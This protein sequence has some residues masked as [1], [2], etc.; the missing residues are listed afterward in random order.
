MFNALCDCCSCC[1][2][3]SDREPGDLE[4]DGKEAEMFCSE[5]IVSVYQEA[6]ILEQPPLGPPPSE[7]IPRDFAPTC[8]ANVESSLLDKMLG[9]LKWIERMD[10]RWCYSYDWPECP[11]FLICCC[12][13]TTQ[14]PCFDFRECLCSCCCGGQPDKVAPP[15]FVIDDQIDDHPPGSQAKQLP[16]S[17]SKGHDVG[18]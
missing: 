11:C 16:E 14:W 3:A 9:D 13:C 7:Y 8:N 2:R 4:N 18:K 15:A 1:E 12:C 6:G 5:L 17:D 10:K